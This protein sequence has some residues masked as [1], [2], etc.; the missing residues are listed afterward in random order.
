MCVHARSFSKGKYASH[1]LHKHSKK[2]VVANSYA[3]GKV[4]Y[5]GWR[6]LDRLFAKSTELVSNEMETLADVCVCFTVL[7]YNEHIT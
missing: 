3:E 7:E 2:G 6:N 5:M 1:I 4:S